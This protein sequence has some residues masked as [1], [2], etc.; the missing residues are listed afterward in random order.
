MLS[1]LPRFNA[2]R[3]Y[4][5]ALLALGILFA[6]LGA[7]LTRLSSALTIPWFQSSAIRH[8][9]AL[10]Y[11]GT[12]FWTAAAGFLSSA[13]L[14]LARQRLLSVELL[15]PRQPAPVE[16]QTANAAAVGRQRG[17]SAAARLRAP[18]AR[19]LARLSLGDR[20]AEWLAR[21][22]PPLVAI[23]CAVLA[24]AGV[25]S[26]WR[27][28]TDTGLDPVTQQIAGALL[29]LVAFPLLVLQRAYANIAPDLLPEAPQLERLLRMPLTACVALATACMLLSVG[30]LWAI[31]IEHAVAIM[32]VVVALELIVRCT[33]ILFAPFAPIELRVSLPDSGLAGGLLRLGL[34]N[35]RKINIAVRQ[36][37]GIDLSR[38]WALSFIQQA[39]L[40][41]LLGTGLFAWGVTGITTLG[42]NQRGVY[43]RLGEPV[44]VFGPGLH[45]H[46]PWPLGSIRPVE[47]GVIH[48]LPI[49]FLLPGGTAATRASSVQA[50]N[51][52]QAVSAEA[53][54]PE[55]ADRLWTDDHPFE[56]SYI[57]ASAEH[58]EQSFQL[59][60]IDMAVMYRVGLSDAAARDAAYRVTDI[61][62][63]IQ[64]VSGQLLVR[65]FTSN[66]LLD[67]LG[68]SRE[69][70]TQQFQAALQQQL[71]RFDTGVE[72][73]GV[74]VEAIHPPPGAASAYHGV[75]AAEIRAN[76]QISVRRGDATRSLMVA[77]QTV[78][79]DRDA[80]V[81]AE[82][83]RVGQARAESVVFTGDRQAYAQDG[84]PF[85]LERW[86]TNVTRALGQSQVVLLDHRLSG[87]SMPALDLR[88]L[89]TLPNDIGLPPGSSNAPGG[90]APVSSAS[91]PDFTPPMPSSPRPSTSGTPRMLTPAPQMPSGPAPSDA[92][93]EN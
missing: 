89:R 72:A 29:I 3:R 40:P 19:L 90:N 66:T 38:S 30:L 55:S 63:L 57:I 48:L 88:N 5:R 82:A 25:R 14:S 49:E 45:F 54:A 11:L 56:G 1:E 22:P 87:Q 23:L 70:F 71:D 61:D 51:R 13:I 74:S 81:A 73:I 44:K 6:V 16:P 53:A 26:L 12:T 46:L 85:L 41:V 78:V 35:L 50:D 18:L 91:V 21:W 58:G 68:R 60:N 52:P 86:L 2:A 42:I 4:G 79:E 59:V 83:E 69:T 62:A 39:T 67:L 31:Q 64:A 75:Q 34:P 47:I 27:M 24:L 7:A 92:T 37:L 20:F 28:P 33:K 15:G 76:T 9:L 32:V 65:Y 84:Y 43:E 93:D 80:A 17:Q 36:Q 8:S 10:G 77:Q